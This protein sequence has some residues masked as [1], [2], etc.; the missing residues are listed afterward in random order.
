MILCRCVFTTPSPSPSAPKDCDA[1]FSN[2]LDVDSAGSSVLVG[3]AIPLTFGKISTSGRTYLF[4]WEAAL[5]KP[6]RLTAGCLSQ[7]GAL[8][9]NIAAIA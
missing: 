2:A 9:R 1:D 5:A 4:R 8:G 3:G 6:V 7:R